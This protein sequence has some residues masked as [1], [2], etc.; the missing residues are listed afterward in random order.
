MFY[1]VFAF[2]CAAQNVWFGVFEVAIRSAGLSLPAPAQAEIEKVPLWIKDFGYSQP[3]ISLLLES[4]QHFRDWI[5]SLNIAVWPDLVWSEL[6]DRVD[7]LKAIRDKAERPRLM[8]SRWAIPSWNIS[9]ISGV[10]MGEYRPR[11]TGLGLRTLIQILRGRS[12]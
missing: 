10:H 11:S 5:K 4:A 3:G 7:E 8:P 2:M 6:D 12:W 1:F 9:V